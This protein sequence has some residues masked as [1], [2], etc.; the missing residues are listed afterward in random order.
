MTIRMYDLAGAEPDRRFSPYCWRIKLALMHK[1]L[2]FETIPWRFT[3][4]SVIAP[5]NSERVPVLIDDGRSVADSWRIAN[6]LDDTYSERPTLFGSKQ[7]RSLARFYNQWTDVV[8][9][10]AI[11]PIVVGDILLHLDAR[12]SDYF[13]S[14]REARL[15]TTLESLAS[16]RG[17][18]LST[19]HQVLEP[20]RQTLAVQPY[21]AGDAPRYPDFIL[22]GAFQWARSISSVRL[23]QLSD[24]IESW[25]QR[26]LDAFDGIARRAPG[27]W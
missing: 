12:D 8:L 18:Y 20:L 22:F 6:Y 21:L 5:Y 23:V 13:R 17:S 10:G 3:E 11:A 9:H 7:E 24:P 1:G 14:S 16:R 19:L 15:G 25:R 4:K 26:L 27:Y 2:E